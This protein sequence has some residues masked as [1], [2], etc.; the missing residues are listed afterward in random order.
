MAR[1][2]PVHFDRIIR[3]CAQSAFCHLVCNYVDSELFMEQV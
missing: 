3:D 1:G 2:L